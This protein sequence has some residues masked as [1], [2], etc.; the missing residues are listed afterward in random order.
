M[1][2]SGTSPLASEQ[3]FT[4]Y[5][6]HFGMVR[7]RVRVL[8]NTL[9]EMNSVDNPF[10]AAVMVLRVIAEGAPNVCAIAL[11]VGEVDTWEQAYLQWFERMKRKFPKKI[12]AEAIKARSLEEFTRLRAVGVKLPE[13][14][15]KSSAR[16]DL[17]TA[18]KAAEVKL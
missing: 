2:L 10:M 7:R 1:S 16:L 9:P 13:V 15:W 6:S 18:E 12:D 8:A 4:E 14:A 5:F 3:G 17:K 11:A